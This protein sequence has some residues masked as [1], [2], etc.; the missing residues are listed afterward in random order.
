[1]CSAGKARISSQVISAIDLSFFELWTVVAFPDL[2]LIFCNFNFRYNQPN[3]IISVIFQKYK[4]KTGFTTKTNTVV[5][6]LG[7][8]RI[9]NRIKLHSWLAK[10][11]LDFG[12]TYAVSRLPEEFAKIKL[13]FPIW[14]MHRNNELNQPDFRLVRHSDGSL[15]IATK[16]LRLCGY[17]YELL[18]QRP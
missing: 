15:T 14:K 12:I 1:M 4:K 6:S 8:F 2:R 18:L 10:G 5:V 7:S 17:I 9:A 13:K 16:C 3:K 11:C